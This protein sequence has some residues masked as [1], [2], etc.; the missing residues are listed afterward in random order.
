MMPDLRTLVHSLTILLTLFKVQPL[1]KIYS[2]NTSLST[3]KKLQ[4]IPSKNQNHI[5]KPA[6]FQQEPRRTQRRQLGKDIKHK[7]MSFDTVSRGARCPA[8]S[9]IFSVIHV[10]RGI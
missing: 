4:K 10:F 3:S 7:T 9:F 5:I 2:T 6:V 8:S 1:R